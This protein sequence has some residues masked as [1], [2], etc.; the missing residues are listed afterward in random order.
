[1]S[2]TNDYEIMLILHPEAEEERRAEIVERIRQ[3]ATEGGGSVDG[4]DEWGKKRFAYEI[5]HLRDG[6]YY[7][8]TL[9]VTADVLDEITRILKITDEVVRF[10]PVRLKEKVTSES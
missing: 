9:T 4:V 1:M 10:K 2:T 7:V 3:T 8:V 5:N 6:Y